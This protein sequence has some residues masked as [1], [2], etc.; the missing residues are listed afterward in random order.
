[1]KYIYIIWDE[2]SPALASSSESETVLQHVYVAI[3]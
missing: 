2:S 1:M 3:G